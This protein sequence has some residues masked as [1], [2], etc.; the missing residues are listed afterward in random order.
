MRQTH[1]NE[2]D[3]GLCFAWIFALL[4]THFYLFLEND[5][6]EISESLFSFLRNVNLP[7]P[8]LFLLQP[9]K[10]GLMRQFVKFP[11]MALRVYF[12]SKSLRFSSSAML[13]RYRELFRNINAVVFL[14]FLNK[15]KIYLD[16]LIP[17]MPWL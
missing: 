2:H 12:N 17:S 3:C 8:L 5:F 11:I 7:S 9:I 6:A 1:C 13:L 15:G 16:K 14:F 10:S 4:L